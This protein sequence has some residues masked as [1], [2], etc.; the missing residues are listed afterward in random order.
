MLTPRSRGGKRLSLIVP[1]HN[2][3]SA[4]DV[5]F[6][7]LD[8]V[9]AGAGVEAE[10]LCIDDG[11]R[12]DTLAR[13]LA[14]SRGDRRLKVIVLARNFGKEAALTAGIDAASG[15][16]VVPI[17][18]DLQDPPELLGEFI[19]LWETGYDVVYGVRTDRASDGVFKRVTAGLFYRAFNQVSDLII[20]RSAGDF[21]LMDRKVIDALKQF[22]ERNRF[23]KGLFAWVGF[24]QIG[25]PYVRPKRSA[26]S[27]SW[28]YYGLWKFALDGITSF[29]TAPLE[30]LDWIRPGLVGR[31]DPG[32]RRPRGVDLGARAPGAGLRFA[33]GGRAVRPGGAVDRLRHP[34]GIRGPAVPGGKRP[35]DLHSQP[36]GRF[37]RLMDRQIYSRM[38]AMEDGHWWFRARRHILEDQIARLPL[39]AGASVLEVGCGTGGNLA[40]LA[41]FGAVAALEPDGE[42]RA[43]ASGRAN[44][45]VSSGALPDELPF[46]ETS[47]DLVA[48][49]DVL[50]HVEEDARSVRSLAKLLKTGGFL[51]TTVPAY[52]WL[53]TD[54]DALHHHKRRYTLSRFRRLLEDSGLE[55][56]KAS[57]FNTIPLPAVAAV[58]LTKKIMKRRGADDEIL[59]GPLMNSFL[60]KLLAAEKY[61]LRIGSFPL[62]V[63]V[64]LIGER[65]G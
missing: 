24:A 29:S 35:A 54:H 36:A 50:E 47:F 55:I 5:L 17:D 11:S 14:R 48:A 43:I 64:L 3:G 12:D 31:R 18:A 26:G 51:V 34:G 1:M 45:D 57:Y 15:D 7:R 49:L 10:I 62:G 25:V 53:W 38:R 40:M 63:S 52:Q 42:A 60:W 37:R 20:P 27:S 2:E 39:P 4:L 19:R 65:R 56:R 58:R 9:L 8:T 32:R 22:P 21:R 16:M 33:H 44:L 46:S 13:I 61:W 6:A 41:R 59:P 28:S 23:M 30:N